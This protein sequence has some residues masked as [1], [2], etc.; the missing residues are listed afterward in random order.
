MT[1][2]DQ[3]PGTAGRALG[4]GENGKIA[5]LLDDVFHRMPRGEQARL[6]EKLIKPLGLL[7][8][9]AVANGVFAKLWLQSGAHASQLRLD[10]GV[11]IG[12]GDVADLAVFVQQMSVETVD[13]LTQLLATSPALVGSAA[14][15]ALIAALTRRI[16][17]RRQRR[18]ATE[19]ASSSPR[20]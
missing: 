3:H 15:A 7:S 8:L 16:Q 10:D 5:A 14:A 13:G 4:A 11:M 12:P 6:L 9:A 20:R 17:A 18:A 2:A 19:T 1:I